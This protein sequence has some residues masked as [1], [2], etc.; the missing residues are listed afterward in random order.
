MPEFL[1]YR[2]E[3]DY[4]WV[5]FESPCVYRDHVL[6]VIDWIKE[7]KV[8]DIGCGDGLITSKIGAKGID[9]DEEGIRLAQTHGVPSEV[10]SA[11]DV[12]GKYDAVFLGDTLEH[13][14]YPDQAIEAIGRITNTVYIVVPTES[15]VDDCNEYNHNTLRVLMMNHG[16]NEESTETVNF[17]IYGKYTKIDDSVQLLRPKRKVAR[18]PKRK[19]PAS[20]SDNS[21]RPRKRATRKAKRS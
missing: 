21:G 10:M 3:G 7:K 5:Q 12:K 9:T 19:A 17:R 20:K 15:D 2:L 6:K 13:L 14:E 4:H 11:Y 16:W 1:K 8:L 18:N